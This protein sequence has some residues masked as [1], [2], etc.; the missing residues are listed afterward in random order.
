M[1]TEAQIAQVIDLIE[2]GESENA[3][4]QAVGIPRSTF[5]TT[6]LRFEAGDKYA[7]ALEGMGRDQVEKMEAAIADMRAG[8]LDAQQARVEIEA[9]KWFA[10]KL[11]PKRFGEKVTTELTGPDGKDLAFTD[12]EAAAR[13]A[14]I[15]E[16]VRQRGEKS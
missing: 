10:S 4:C 5:R 7:R 1:A 9:R 8:T 12:H 11:F 16:A 14:A 13:L 2:T 6:A 3:A 15:L